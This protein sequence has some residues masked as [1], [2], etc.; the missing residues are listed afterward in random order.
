[1]KLKLRNVSDRY[2][3]MRNAHKL[4]DSTNFSQVFIAAD[5]TLLQRIRRKREV[6]GNKRRYTKLKYREINN[7]SQATTPTNTAHEYMITA[8]QTKP[9]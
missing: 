1:M 2:L 3:I 8:R 9:C 4:K 7:H 6:I 5:L